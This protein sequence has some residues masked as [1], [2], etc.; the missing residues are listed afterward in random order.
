MDIKNIDSLRNDEGLSRQVHQ[1]LESIVERMR[2]PIHEP[3]IK[4]P[5]ELDYVPLHWPL[6]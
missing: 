1:T 5:I 2:T 3:V 6:D 4:E